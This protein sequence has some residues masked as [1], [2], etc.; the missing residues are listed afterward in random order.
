MAVLALEDLPP[1]GQPVERDRLAELGFELVAP[2]HFLSNL[3]RTVFA[4]S[5][6]SWDSERARVNA[7]W[8]GEVP[9]A[10]IIAVWP[11]VTSS[12]APR[13]I[14]REPSLLI[15]TTRRATT[16]GSLASTTSDGTSLTSST[17]SF[18]RCTIADPLGNARGGLRV[19]A[20][21]AI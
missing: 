11:V 10:S 17:S 18:M 8:S 1:R 16:G 2:A 4:D 7:S 19:S 12:S 6:G 15:S 3:R 9:C 5:F 13:A 21:S 20:H 14:V